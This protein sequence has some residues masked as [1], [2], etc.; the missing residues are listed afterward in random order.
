MQFLDFALRVGEW[1]Q[2]FGDWLSRN[3]QSLWRIFAVVLLC[4]LVSRYAEK[5]IKRILERTIRNDLY[6]SPTDR[7]KRLKTLTNLGAGITRF[8]VWITG[9]IVIIG[10][11]GVNT[12]PF[13]A[14][15][16]VIGIGLGLGAQ[17]LINDLVSGVFIISENQYRIGDYVELEGVSG[18][19][20]DITIRTTVL[21]DLSGAVHHVPNGSIVVAT[22]MSMGFG[23]INLDITVE[24]DTDINKLRT[25]IDKVGEKI[26]NEPELKGEIIEPPRFIRIVDYT[27][28][29]VTVKVMGKTTGGK[30]LEIKSVFYTELKQALDHAK[31]KLAF[32]PYGMPATTKKRK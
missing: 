16:G 7:E 30:Q 28:T 13:L 17:K 27:G 31:I 24:G 3:S 14:S 1:Q 20:E 21:R 18:S 9:A 11:I 29:G 23:Q 26:S 6:Q 5:G 25:I 19:V 10:L 4:W 15:A 2:S 32:V 12:A 22:N 8:I